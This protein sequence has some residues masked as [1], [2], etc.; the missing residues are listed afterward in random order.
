MVRALAAIA[1]GIAVLAAGP[2]DSRGAQAGSDRIVLLADS[3]TT[4]RTVLLG[5]RCT[6]IAAFGSTPRSTVENYVLSPRGF[7]AF[8]RRPAGAPYTEIVVRGLGPSARSRTVA[9]VPGSTDSFAFSPDGRQ[10]AVAA[11][12]GL[13]VESLRSGRSRRLRRPEARAPRFS[14]AFA[15]S[16]PRVSASVG[17]ARPLGPASR[18]AHRDDPL[19]GR[20]T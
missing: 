12:E 17:D 2:T 3:W 20:V 1:V 4:G 9:R 10:L 15:S 18:Q 11:G 14:G 13:V 16:G 6:P 7:L 8:T 5:D 19:G